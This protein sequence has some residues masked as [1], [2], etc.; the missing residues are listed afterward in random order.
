VTAT[1][2]RVELILL[3]EYMSRGNLTQ[4]I[5]NDPDLSFRR[6]LSIAVD[7]AS[8]M[9]RIHDLNFIHRDI[10]P[11]NILVDANYKAKIGDMGI[12]KIYTD[13]NKKLAEAAAS[14]THTLVGCR[15][16]M[17]PEFYTRK[18]SKKLDIFTYG[19]TLNEL[20]GG[21]HEEEGKKVIVTHLA[22][23]FGYFVEKCTKDDPDQR[24]TSKEL[25]NDLKFF[26]LISNKYVKDCIP[27]YFNLNNEKKNHVFKGIY[28]RTLE[29]YLKNLA[30]KSGEKEEEAAKQTSSKE[31]KANKDKEKQLV[32]T[33]QFANK[34]KKEKQKEMKDHDPKNCVLS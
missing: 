8:G 20:Y 14:R 12:A 5:Q 27:E 15:L 17:P 29:Y 25:E 21:D 9:S 3:T 7:V 10:R 34:S 32:D 33:N 4:V 26:S 18:Y 16:Y 24:P 30:S 11:D 19:L 23:V 2:A 28:Q 6:R 13:K 1:G 22:P 31:K